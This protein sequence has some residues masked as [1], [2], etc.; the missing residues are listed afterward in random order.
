M[1]G[2]LAKKPKGFSLRLSVKKPSF[3]GFEE[4]G[5]RGGKSRF[6]HLRFARIS[7]K[8]REER[9]K[10]SWKKYLLYASQCLSLPLLCGQQASAVE[11]TP[12]EGGR[13]D[14]LIH[15]HTSPK[16]HRWVGEESRWRRFANNEFCCPHA[17]LSLSSQRLKVTRKKIKKS[18]AEIR[19]CRGWR[20][21]DIVKPE[22]CLRGGEEGEG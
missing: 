14:P 18:L 19:E 17:R 15:T 12:L 22:A 4:R 2:T 7:T 3:C 6:L 21:G 10:K 16:K 13:L 8:M 20:K 5:W 9:G 1:E 11:K